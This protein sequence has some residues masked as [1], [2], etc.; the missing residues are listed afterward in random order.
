MPE[1]RQA[2]LISF[3]INLGPRRVCGTTIAADL[4]AGRVTKACNSMSQYIN[5]NGKR[6][7]ALETRRNDPVW[8]EKPWCLMKEAPVAPPWWQTAAKILLFMR[9]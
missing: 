9:A 7:K 5:A 1:H 2:S 3:V 4:N 8:G 6:L